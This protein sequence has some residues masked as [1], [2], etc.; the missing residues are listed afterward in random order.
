MGLGGGGGG[1]GGRGGGV[2]G[3]GGGETDAA[4]DGGEVVFLAGDVDEA[5]R[6]EGRGVDGAE[7]GGGDDEGEAE[8]ANG[9]EDSR[10]ELDGDGVGFFDSGQREDEEVGD[11]G[12]EVGEDYHGHGGVEDAGE[13][14]G[15]GF[16]LA[17][18]V[19]GVV[20]AVEGPEAGVEGDSPV[21]CGEA[22]VVEPSCRFP[23]GAGHAFFK[24]KSGGRDD[25]ANDGDAD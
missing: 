23:V 22:G 4:E 25:D 6:G 14:A 1:V 7:A 2:G 19:V 17:D 13:V 15:R 8:G 10:A 16:E 3:R 18:D 21:S 11:V 9:A 12:E 20:P 24:A 5:A